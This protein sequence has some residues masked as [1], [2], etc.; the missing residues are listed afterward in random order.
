MIAD[1]VCSTGVEFPN[2]E[3][4]PD[5]E[6]PERERELIEFRDVLLNG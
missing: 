6:L 1:S 4:C 2:I 3:I 5:D